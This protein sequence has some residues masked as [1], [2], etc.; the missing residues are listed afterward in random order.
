MKQFKKIIKLFIQKIHSN[1]IDLRDLYIYHRN[2]SKKIN[3]SVINKKNS[4]ALIFGNGPSLN[5]ILNQTVK[6]ENAYIFVCNGFA[7]KSS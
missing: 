2:K 3:Y 1:Y 5:E 4:T 6:L 7:T